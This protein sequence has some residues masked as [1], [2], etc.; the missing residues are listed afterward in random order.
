M[1]TEAAKSG[2]ELAVFRKF[3]SASHLPIATDSLRKGCALAGEPD[4]LCELA[5][6]LVAFELAEC[7]APE[8]AAAEA[9]S[10]ESLDGV[11][12]CWGTDVSPGTLRR[13]LGKHYKV[14][15]PLHLLLYTNARTALPDEVLIGRLRSELQHGLGQFQVVWFFGSSIHRLAASET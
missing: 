6:E 9:A 1:G 2:V 3:A 4:I 8:F 13:K 7:C 12:T 10:H 14:S 5:G 15:C 11:V